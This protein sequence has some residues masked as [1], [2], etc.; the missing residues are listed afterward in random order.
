VKNNAFGARIRDM[1]YKKFES[2]GKVFCKDIKRRKLFW[3]IIF[4]ILIFCVILYFGS[5]VL[6]NIHNIFS[7]VT[8]ATT[9]IS[10]IMSDSPNGVQIGGSVYAPVSVGNQ[11]RQLTNKE[12]E[13]ILS[14]LKNLGVSAA[15]F[16][17]N[18][19]DG[20]TNRYAQQ[21]G[22]F[23]LGEGYAVFGLSPTDVRM[24]AGVPEGQLN[25]VPISSSTARIEIGPQ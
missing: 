17:F 20:E 24:G 8:P 19:D 18:T 23:L 5:S 14:Q 9:P 25:I 11:P 12:K 13:G 1:D 16:Y 3:P 7:P 6:A 15:L 2:A 10:Q 21:I 22:N 4:L